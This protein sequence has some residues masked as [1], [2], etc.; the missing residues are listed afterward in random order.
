MCFGVA[1]VTLLSSRL[2]RAVDCALLPLVID[3]VIDG[4]L[5]FGL[6]TAVLVGCGTV[7]CPCLGVLGGRGFRLEGILGG[8]LGLKM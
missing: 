6:S 5:V 3:D 7:G 2:E 4:L 1:R 8:S